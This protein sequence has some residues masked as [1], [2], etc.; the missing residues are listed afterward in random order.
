M[1]HHILSRLW[2]FLLGELETFRASRRSVFCCKN[3]IEFT[4]W[5]LLSRPQTSKTSHLHSMTVCTRHCSTA[6][7]TLTTFPSGSRLSNKGQGI[8][9]SP[10]EESMQ[11]GMSIAGT[12]HY[13]SGKAVGS[14]DF[15][16]Y[17][18]LPQM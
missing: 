6:A 2:K 1:S 4:R 3:R 18:Q 9:L 13:P 12:G 11:M 7:L 15:K 5:C 17:I 10:L 16:R 8:P 14:R